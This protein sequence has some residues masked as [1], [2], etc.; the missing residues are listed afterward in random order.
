[1]T[2]LEWS[3]TE[4]GYESAGY[5]ITRTGTHGWT[6]HCEPSL[7]PA[8]AKQGSTHMRAFASLK[9]ARAAALHM[10][11]V[12]IRRLKLIRHVTLWPVMS[13]LGRLLRHDDPRHTSQRT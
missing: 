10:E 13:I 4:E 5:R 1:M 3:E 8:V 7:M 6:V 12:R 11:V 9:S 2:T